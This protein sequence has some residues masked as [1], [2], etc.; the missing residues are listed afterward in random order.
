MNVFNNLYLTQN[1][2]ALLY[3]QVRPCIGPASSQCKSSQYSKGVLHDLNAK[4]SRILI[5]NSQTEFSIYGS[6]KNKR[7]I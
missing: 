7:T 5:A 6:T 4:Y 3:S 1:N 2:I